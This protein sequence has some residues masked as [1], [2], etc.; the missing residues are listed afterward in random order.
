MKA[1]LS[2]PMEGKTDEEIAKNRGFAEHWLDALGYEVVD[3]LFDFDAE[4]LSMELV[5]NEPLYYLAKSIEAM[6]K[7]DAVYF[8]EGWE[9][10]RGCRIEHEAAKAYGLDIIYEE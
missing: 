1:M 8:C 10:A 9:N 4:Y 6:S 7:C 2:Q 3:T 5:E